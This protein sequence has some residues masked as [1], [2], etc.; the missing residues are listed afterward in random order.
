MRR[1]AHLSDLHICDAHFLKDL[2]GEVVASLNEIT[3]DIVVITG[4][5]TQNGYYEE[6]EDAR[7]WIEQIRCGNKVVVPGNHDSRNVGY[8]FFEE[9][10]GERSSCDSFEEPPVL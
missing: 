10:F 5:L 9:I 4:D 8:L 7:K 3:P 6:F 2:A 1:I